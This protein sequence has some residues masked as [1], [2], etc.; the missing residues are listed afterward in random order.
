MC[1]AL[2]GYPQA[3]IDEDVRGAVDR[4]TLQFAQLITTKAAEECQKDK[5][6]IM[7]GNDLINAMEILG[8]D[9]YV[10]P[11]SE[12]LRRYRESKGKLH[13]PASLVD[14]PPPSNFALGH[15]PATAMVAAEMEATTPPQPFG[16][17]LGEQ[18]PCDITELDLHTDVYAVWSAQL[19]R[20]APR[21]L[22]HLPMNHDD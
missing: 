16:S 14:I 4:C 17:V 12:Y 20:Q 22:F 9:H 19:Q 6:S 15:A 8:F 13:T 7:T 21:P 18:R 11:L 10:G 5:R 1:R 3:K 2:Q